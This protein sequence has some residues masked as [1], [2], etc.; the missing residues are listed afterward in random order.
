MCRC[1]ELCDKEN[2]R[3]RSIVGRMDPRGC[4]LPISSTRY[5]DYTSMGGQVKQVGL[6]AHACGFV[7][8]TPGCQVVSGLLGV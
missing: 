8:T 2:Y 6:L 3:D 4:V 5:I 7:G 1:H